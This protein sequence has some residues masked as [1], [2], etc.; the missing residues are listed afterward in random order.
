MGS[1]EMMEQHAK[2]LQPSNQAKSGEEYMYMILSQI[3]SPRNESRNVVFAHAYAY[4]STSASASASPS[5]T[6]SASASASAYAY[7][8]AS[9]YA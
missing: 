9:A 8:Y 2:N 3:G 5:D 1:L 7:A 4:A 6:A